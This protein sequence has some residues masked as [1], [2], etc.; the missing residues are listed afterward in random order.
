MADDKFNFNPPEV[1]APE[2][3]IP[4]EELRQENDFKIE[5]ILLIAYNGAEY[6]LDL[7]K[8]Q[9]NIYE[10]IFNN[11]ISG[12]IE[13]YDANDLPNFMPMM[14][15]E[16][17][18]IIFTRPDIVKG[19]PVENPDAKDKLPD[20]EMEFRIVKMSDRRRVDERVQQYVLHFIS[21][22]V[23]KNLKVKMRRSFIGKPYSE[24]V[25]IVY[26]EKIKE[27]KDLVVEETEFDHDF[28]ASNISPFQMFNM[29]ASRS[30]SIEYGTSNYVFYED[31]DQFNYVSISK[32]IDGPIVA[33]YGYQIA[34]VL[35]APVSGSRDIAHDLTSAEEYNFSGSFDILRKMQEG[36]YASKLITVDTTR[37]IM[38]E[39]EYHYLD[40]FGSAPRLGDSPVNTEDLDA[41]GEADTFVK[42]MGT[43]K[44]H[45]K[46]PHIVDKEPGIKPIHIEETKLQRYSL[47]EQIND[48][49]I[50]IT[51][52]GDPRRKVG[53]VI[54]FKLPR[55][56]ADVDRPPE[57]DQY[58]AGK[59]LI[60]ALRH[61]FQQHKY[62][63]Q[64]EI[65]KD[66]YI[67]EPEHIDPIDYYERTY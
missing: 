18:K 13:L 67:E 56:T 21:E 16:R 65:I 60:I 20:Y 37:K 22:E 63:M 12:N 5:E 45:D 31:K 59:Y 49:K 19:A 43:N 46:V 15:E 30:L 64:L 39:E 47:L 42:L 44:D 1:P 41:L 3:N 66:S 35:D 61:R 27:K 57:E 58:L 52:S 23:I 40:E 8:I 38:R 33:E 2:T 24:M 11:F 62:S 34:N 4:T 54:E 51:L 32:L 10:D 14:G 9:L 55:T 28:V 6:K 53:E 26:D 29:L 48:K 36:M 7:V 50:I 17:L 25:E